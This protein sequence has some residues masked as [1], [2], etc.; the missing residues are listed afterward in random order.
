VKS[1]LARFG[2][3]FAL[4]VLVAVLVVANLRS[5]SLPPNTRADRVLVVKSERT[6]TLYADD[7]AL[8][9]Y[10]VALGRKSYR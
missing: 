8:K 7:N 9:T 5:E 2:L 1:Q 4:V 10:S 6:L 3:A